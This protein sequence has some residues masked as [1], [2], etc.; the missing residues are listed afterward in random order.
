MSSVDFNMSPLGSVFYGLCLLNTPLGL[1]GFIYWKVKERKAATAAEF[2][3][4]KD[5]S[6]ACLISMVPFCG[7]FIALMGDAAV[8]SGM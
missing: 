2:H 8:K 7:P 1:A 5:R 6:G 4:A 3:K